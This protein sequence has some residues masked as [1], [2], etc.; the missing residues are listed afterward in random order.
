MKTINNGRIHFIIL[1]SIACYLLLSCN[2]PFELP[3]QE[4]P[5]AGAGYFSLSINGISAGRTIVPIGVVQDDFEAYTLEFFAAGNNITPEVSETRTIDDLSDPVELD[6]GTWNLVVTAYRDLAGTDPIAQGSITVVIAPGATVNRSVTLST[7][8]GNGT[9]IFQWLIDYPADVIEA[10]VTITPYDEAT[11]TAQQTLYFVGGTPVV[12][13][14]G[15]VHLN[16]GFYRV[17]YNL[18][19]DSYQ[20]A[21]HRE[22]LHIYNNWDSDFTFTFSESHFTNA[23]IVTSGDDSGAGTLRSTLGSAPTGSTIYIDHSV[24][25]I[26]LDETLWIDKDNITIEGNGVIITRSASFTSNYGLLSATVHA[27]EVT[28]NRIH[29]KDSQAG[30]QG[31]GAIYNQGDLT[32]ESCIFSGNRS[33]GSY[34][35]GGGAINNNNSGTMSVIGCT[36]YGN[37]AGHGGAIVNNGTLFLGGNLF[38]GN[39]ATQSGKAVFTMTWD[40]GVT[41]SLGY[42]AVDVLLGTNDNQSG[43]AAAAG[44]SV[45]NALPISTI[46]YRLL[47]GSGAAGII[48]SLPADYPTVDFYGNPISAPAAAG[49]VQGTASETGYILDLTVN[50]KAGGS[51]KT[52]PAPNA[53]GFISG[54]VAI[55]ATAIGIYDFTHWLV[56]GENAGS[57][58][59]LSLNITTHSKIQAVFSTTYIVDDFTDDYNS[60]T[61]PGTLRYAL[62]NARDSD[63]IRFTGVTPG[64]SEVITTAILPQITESLTIEGNGVTITMTSPW[65]FYSSLL[66]ISNATV[67]ISRIWFKNIAVYNGAPI[68]NSGTLNLESCIFSDNSSDSNNSGGTISNN[69]TLSIKGCTFFGNT[70]GV[71]GGAIANDGTF[72]FEGNLFYGNTAPTYPVVSPWG[73]RNSNGY[74]VVDA[75]FGTGETQSGWTTHA[76]DRQINSLTV[77]PITFK[78]FPSGGATGVITS[79]PSGYPTVDFYGNVI[80]V[81]AAAGAVQSTTN[82]AGYYL[83][84]TVNNSAAGTVDVTVSGIPD[85]D[86]LVSG[87]VTIEV[88]PNIGYDFTH[89]LVNGV[90]QT[91]NPLSITLTTHTFVQAIFKREVTVDN[92]SSIWWIDGERTL[93]YVLDHAQDGDIINID[94]T[95]AGNVIELTGSLPTISKNITIKGNGV[96]IMRDSSTSDKFT[97]LRI[98]SSGAVTISRVHFKDG[99][100]EYW[101][102]AIYNQGKLT[103][104]SCVFSGNRNINT[105]NASGGAI[106]SQGNTTVM[107]CSFYD[108][109]TDGYGGAI[110]LTSGTLTLSGNLFYG[111]DAPNG[112]AITPYYGGG[113]VTS[114]GYNIVDVPLGTGNTQS[115]W[116][117]HITDVYRAASP[118]VNAA[119]GDLTPVSGVKSIIP[120][121]PANFPAKDFNGNDRTFPGAPGAIK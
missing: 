102:G 75:P 5:H 46:S 77:S 63:I 73:N 21:T 48:T 80:N 40:S 99:Q 20:K 86:G 13:K 29:F 65:S 92:P 111:N 53:D 14:T 60:E 8:G 24:G 36:F 64:I 105:N 34:T 43:F 90:V 85:A 42:N 6:G 113:T 45:I 74:N 55:T 107:G 78:V 50:N 35:Q 110:L 25:T 59:P 22:I 27:Y 51:V 95:S 94:L 17:V 62:V 18:V 84:V 67:T 10:S 93:Y 115:G 89:W 116:A 4:K 68:S 96:T 30:Y 33:S 69:G 56:N 103:L 16:T 9:G 26:E 82:P 106:N 118:F 108:N 61:T 71:N 37:S 49:A 28:I 97:L 109:S 87:A 114:L 3:K 79:V 11:G 91:D 15:F 7:F 98:N 47:S 66:R 100:T 81:P 76:T 57:A 12:T 117:P 38:Y 112:K 54:T 70:S 1:L 31:G 104:E 39:T 120:S 23:I 58:N 119:G 101:G 32:L 2:S 19:N 121:R 72:S 83:D 41:N 88:T 44:D 52:S